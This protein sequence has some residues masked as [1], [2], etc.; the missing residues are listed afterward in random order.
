[1]KTMNWTPGENDT[2]HYYDT[3]VGKDY[4]CVYA[5]KKY[6][7]IWYGCYNKDGSI[8]TIGD[9][10]FNDRQKKKSLGGCPNTIRFL[11][12]KDPE[13]MM[14]KVEYAYQNG[15]SEVNL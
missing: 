11:T 7:N 8:I 15:L 2:Q 3:E 5:H 1:M 6:P 9:K 13:Y 10:K 12:S 14:E 4:L